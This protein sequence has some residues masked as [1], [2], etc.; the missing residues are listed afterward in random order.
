MQIRLSKSTG[1]PHEGSPPATVRALT[2]LLPFLILAALG[3]LFITTGAR[4]RAAALN[5]KFEMID[6]KDGSLSFTPAQFKDELAAHDAIYGACFGSE[7]VQYVAF[8]F[9][10][11]VVEVGEAVTSKSQDAWP[12][13]DHA[14]EV[15][16][17]ASR[18][19][20]T[21]DTVESLMTKHPD[22]VFGVLYQSDGEATDWKAFDVAVKRVA[23]HTNLAFVAVSGV[24]SSS[25]ARLKKAMEPLGERFMAFDPVD[26]NAV[27]AQKLSMLTQ[28]A[29]RGK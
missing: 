21:L 10:R 2:A 17:S 3:A 24:I 25:R 26:M 27:T 22:R 8:A 16:P 18:F 5:P 13:L 6:F 28:R 15:D 4:Q 11:N 19:G 1:A 7:P 20:P 12:L 9:G 29:R 14:V 23:R